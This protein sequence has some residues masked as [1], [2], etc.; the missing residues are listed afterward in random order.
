MFKG[1]FFLLTLNVVIKKGVVSAG[2]QDRNGCYIIREKNVAS[3]IFSTCEC[4]LILE[5]NPAI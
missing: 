4:L 3:I 5:I 1:I 2:V